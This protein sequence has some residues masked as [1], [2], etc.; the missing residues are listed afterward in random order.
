MLHS[1]GGQGGG[2]GY[3]SNP[4]FDSVTV[5]GPAFFQRSSYKYHNGIGS[6]AQ[7]LTQQSNC[8]FLNF[9]EDDHTAAFILPQSIDIGL[10]IV[11]YTFVNTNDYGIRIVCNEDQIIREAFGITT[12]GGYTETLDN[13]ASTTI[14]AISSTEF[15]A[16]GP[17]GSWDYQ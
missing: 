6:P 1:P 14:L 15:V 17:T 16:L 11:F 12:L 7:I 8:V 13:G 3:P 4:T 2:G 10:G 9:S 5:N